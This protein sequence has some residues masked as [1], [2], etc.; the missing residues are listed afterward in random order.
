MNFRFSIILKSAAGTFSRPMAHFCY[1]ILFIC[2]V[3][4]AKTCLDIY[5]VQ[6]DC[7]PLALS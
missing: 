3:L 4:Y 2:G 1:T 5:T 7:Q 6:G